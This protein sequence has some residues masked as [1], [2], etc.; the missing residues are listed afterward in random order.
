MAD[1]GGIVTDADVA[2]DDDDEEEE[3]DLEESEERECLDR[4]RLRLG[5][6]LLR[7]EGRLLERLLL[8]LYESLSETDSLEDDVTLL[9]LVRR[10]LLDCLPLDLLLLESR[11]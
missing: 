11:E 9:L 5:E 2:C 3:D 4:G 6:F 7:L 8:R 1:T 10:C